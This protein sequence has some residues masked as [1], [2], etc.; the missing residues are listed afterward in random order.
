[1]SNYIFEN[2][3]PQAGQRFASSDDVVGSAHECQHESK[4]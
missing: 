2:A 4:G 3:A 1:M